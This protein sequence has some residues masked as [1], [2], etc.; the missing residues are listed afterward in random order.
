MLPVYIHHNIKSQVMRTKVARVDGDLFALRDDLKKFLF[1]RY[2]MDFIS[3]VGEVY[4]KVIFRGDFE[5]DFK[6]FLIAKG[7]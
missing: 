5:Q 2:Q 6:E 4:G 1:E 3:Q 7:F